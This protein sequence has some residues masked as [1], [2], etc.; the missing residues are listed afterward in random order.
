MSAGA[1]PT[2]LQGFP[3][4]ISSHLY[5]LPYPI[6]IDIEMIQKALKGVFLCL[7]ISDEA[8]AEVT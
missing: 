6:V 7:G 5:Q 2:C 1:V 3:Y 4:A 8:R